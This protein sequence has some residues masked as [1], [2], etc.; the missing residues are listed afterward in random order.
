[1][2]PTICELV[3]APIP[4]SVDGRS[5]V[6]MLHGE[7]D[8]LYPEVFTHF[9]DV[10]RAIRTD[11]WK[12]IFY[13]QAHR[14]QLFHLASDPHELHNLLDEPEHAAVLADLRIRLARWRQS[15]RDPTLAD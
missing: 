12:Y 4:A 3:G 8:A 9:R 10:Q 5:L 14:E 2:H 11:E 6:P 13:P 1:L 7:R 15:W